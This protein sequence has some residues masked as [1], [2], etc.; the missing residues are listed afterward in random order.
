M[1]GTE[2]DTPNGEES[3]LPVVDAESTHLPPKE[4]ANDGDS[5]TMDAFSADS[6]EQALVLAS[7]ADAGSSQD[8][9]QPVVPGRTKRKHQNEGM[10]T[11]LDVRT[12]LSISGG[13]GW[14]GDLKVARD[15]V[16]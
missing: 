10:C 5:G 6:T 3:T 12:S 1:S 2:T 4:V 7:T 13:I 8:V 9:P 11:I 15:Y 14:Q 16:T